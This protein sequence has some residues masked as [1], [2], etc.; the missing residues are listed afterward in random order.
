MKVEFLFDSGER[1]TLEMAG[2]LP[3]TWEWPLMRPVTRADESPAVPLGPVTLRFLKMRYTQT[4][5]P[6]YVEEALWQR[7]R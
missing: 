4:L 5:R 3:D 6:Y 2:P 1:H 7:M